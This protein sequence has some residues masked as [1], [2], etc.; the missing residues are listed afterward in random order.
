[1]IFDI[2]LQKNVFFCYE[3][4]KRRHFLVNVSFFSVM[5]MLVSP[6]FIEF[7]FCPYYIKLAMN[8]FIAGSALQA[9]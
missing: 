7:S 9:S 3:Q 2:I 8:S 4:N 1:M 5:G 6:L